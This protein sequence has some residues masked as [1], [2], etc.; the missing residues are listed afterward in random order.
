MDNFESTSITIK[1]ADCGAYQRV[2]ARKGMNIV[3]AEDFKVFIGHLTDIGWI[4]DN[5][6]QCPDCARDN[7]LHGGAGETID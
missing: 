5:R 7:K 1:C 2:W 3:E 4:L 6:V